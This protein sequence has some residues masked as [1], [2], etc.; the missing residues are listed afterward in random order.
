MDIL[1]KALEKSVQKKNSKVKEPKA[2]DSSQLN[3][4]N[5][6]Q[7]VNLDWHHLAADGYCPL[8]K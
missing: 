2:Q 3:I 6:Q 8:S 5:T 1:E 7:T 4:E